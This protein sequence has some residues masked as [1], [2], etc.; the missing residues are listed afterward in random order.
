M[1]NN[2]EKVLSHENVN[3]ILGKV[4]NGEAHEDDAVIIELCKF[5]LEC[6]ESNL[7]SAKTL[8]WSAPKFIKDPNGLEYKEY[9]LSSNSRVYATMSIFERVVTVEFNFDYIRGVQQFNNQIMA[10]SFISNIAG[11]GGYCISS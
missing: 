3:R 4:S 11:I 1:N 7:D 6:Q 2:K 10:L 9:T 5:W 8:V